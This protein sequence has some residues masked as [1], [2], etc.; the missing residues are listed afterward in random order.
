MFILKYTV[1]NV[2]NIHIIFSIYTLL[3][4]KRLGIIPQDDQKTH[5][6]K[7]QILLIALSEVHV[8]LRNLIKSTVA[9]SKVGNRLYIKRLFRHPQVTQSVAII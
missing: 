9:W 2:L 4:L 6:L 7:P 8:L 5:S 1:K 3:S